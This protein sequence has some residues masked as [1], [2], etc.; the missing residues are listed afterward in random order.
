MR[1]YEF[2]NYLTDRGWRKECADRLFNNDIIE[3]YLP[4]DVW[5]NTLVGAFSAHSK[6]SIAPMTHLAK[7]LNV[8]VPQWD[9]LTKPKLN[10]FRQYLTRNMAQNTAVTYIKRL[11]AVMN[12][13]DEFIPVKNFR[14]ALALK[15]EPS[16]HVA[17][18]EEEVERI[19]NYQPRNNSESDIKRAFMLECLCGA[20]S[21]DIDTLTPDNIHDGWLTYVSQKTKTETSVPVHKNLMHYLTTPRY[22]NEYYRSVVC[23][24]IKRICRKCGIDE[25]VKIF[26]KGKWVQV[27]KYEL[28]GSHTARRSFATQLALRGVPVPTISKLMGHSNVQMTSKYICIDRKD[29]GDTA[30]AFFNS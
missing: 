21:C 25:M 28:V 18:T 1:Q 27:P 26:T 16:Q 13:Y 23:D 11:A 14:S 12:I 10:E 30:M 20:R 29:I 9:D 4:L 5:K 6:D 17:L 7:A 3:S 24:T 2:T 8:M 15:S 22:N 19:H